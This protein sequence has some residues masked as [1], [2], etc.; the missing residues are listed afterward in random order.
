MSETPISE[1]KPDELAALLGTPPAKVETPQSTE[2][3]EDPKLKEKIPGLEITYGMAEALSLS[4]E[5]IEKI[6]QYKQHVLPNDVFVIPTSRNTYIARTCT[7]FEWRQKMGDWQVEIQQRTQEFIAQGHPE[8]KVQQT[9]EMMIKDRIICSLLLEPVRF[10][11]PQA[12]RELPPGEVEHI[13]ASI[14]AA[15]GFGQQVMP[16]KM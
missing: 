8:A 11:D 15:L 1:K 4:P 14:E 5:T 10:T 13:Y 2:Q 6:R 12:L 3:K 16:I 9:M 7:R